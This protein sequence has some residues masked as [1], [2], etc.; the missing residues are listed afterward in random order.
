MSIKRSF[1]VYKGTS[2]KYNKLGV[3]SFN[4]YDL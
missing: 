4:L 3:L 1:Y 2:N